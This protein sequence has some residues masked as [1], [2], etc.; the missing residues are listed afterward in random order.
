[1]SYSSTDEAFWDIICSVAPL[2]KLVF[3]MNSILVGLLLVSAPFLT[4]GSDSFYVAIFGA[5][6]ITLTFLCTGLVL[7]LCQRRVE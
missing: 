3:V 6:F 1:M 5:G 4:I 7:L 2:L